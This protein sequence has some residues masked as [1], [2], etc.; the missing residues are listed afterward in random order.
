MVPLT[1]RYWRQVASNAP[2]A[3][4]LQLCSD[5]WPGQRTGYEDM[6]G[7]HIVRTFDNDLWTRNPRMPILRLVNYMSRSVLA[8]LEWHH[9]LK[10]YK[11]FRTSG[12]EAPARNMRRFFARAVHY[13][14]VGSTSNAAN[15]SANPATH[16]NAH[17]AGSCCN[18]TCRLASLKK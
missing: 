16:V 14:D 18:Q 10:P 3:R 17:C 13:V 9:K 12:R 8:K 11:Q 2:D 4:S 15:P 6:A 5:L 7:V 1:K